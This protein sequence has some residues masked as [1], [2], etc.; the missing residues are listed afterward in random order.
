M[1]Y[2]KLPKDRDQ[3]SLALQHMRKSSTKLDTEWV[4]RESSLTNGLMGT[5][6]MGQVR[7]RE[8]PKVKPSLTTIRAND[9]AVI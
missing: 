7:E 1:L 4:L 8:E 6:E 2:H 3:V 9:G 5:N